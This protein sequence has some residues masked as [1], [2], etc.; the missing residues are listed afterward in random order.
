M[1]QR[2]PAVQQQNTTMPNGI[3]VFSTN[4]GLDLI[5][6]KDGKQQRLIHLPKQSQPIK[7]NDV[8]FQLIIN[9]EKRKLQARM[10]DGKLLNFISFENN[11]RFFAFLEPLQATEREALF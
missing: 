9:P 10:D 3:T 6:R 4:L 1:K 11:S 2:K 5:Y 7:L 8:A